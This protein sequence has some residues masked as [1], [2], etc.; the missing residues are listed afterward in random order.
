MAS[1]AGRIGAILVC[2]LSKPSVSRKDVELPP[3]LRAVPV[4]ERLRS[5]R[6]NLLEFPQVF[7]SPSGSA[8][9][10]L[11]RCR[12]ELKGTKMKVGNILPSRYNEDFAYM[13]TSGHIRVAIHA[14]F[15]IRP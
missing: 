4:E 6:M 15:T 3:F 10:S 2:S 1:R 12:Y 11:Y 9:V 13:C 8:A 5:L 7:V 14:L